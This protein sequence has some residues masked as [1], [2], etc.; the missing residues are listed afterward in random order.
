MK[1]H[2]N[3]DDDS[4]DYWASDAEYIG[5][6]ENFAHGDTPEEA[7]GEFWAKTFNTD[8]A[9]ALG[10]L[11]MDNPDKFGMDVDLSQVAVVPDIKL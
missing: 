7:I 10:K 1:I 3:Q 11:I 6:S 5:I 9:H 2:I 4:G 8:T